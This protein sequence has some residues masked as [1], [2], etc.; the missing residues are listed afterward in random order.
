[1]NEVQVVA[2]ILSGLLR[3]TPTVVELLTGSSKE[4]LKERIARAR[5]SAQDPIDTTPEDA[6]RLEALRQILEGT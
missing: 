5:A 3:V 2:E 4:D 6:A 1:M